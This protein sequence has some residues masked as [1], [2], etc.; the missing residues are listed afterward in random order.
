MLVYTHVNIS[1]PALYLVV[2]R[3]SQ[4]LSRD[5]TSSEASALLWS[6]VVHVYL[7]ERDYSD[8]HTRVIWYTKLLPLITPSISYNS[9]P[10][11]CW[12]S[13]KGS[14]ESGTIMNTAAC[15]SS[16]LSYSL[17]AS[18]SV[19]PQVGSSSPSHIHSLILHISLH[20]FCD[21]WWFIKLANSFQQHPLLWLKASTGNYSAGRI[22]SASAAAVTLHCDLNQSGQLPWPHQHL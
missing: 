7:R 10:C 18:Y 20:L 8:E 11:S 9:A 6:K 4:L 1:K 5:S 3:L 14:R 12:V 16:R 15:F 22:D 19:M 13:S 21:W 17:C 2:V